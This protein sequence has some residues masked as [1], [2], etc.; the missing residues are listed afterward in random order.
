MTATAAVTTTATAFMPIE[1][2]QLQAVIW[3]CGSYEYSL[4][5]SPTVRRGSSGNLQALEAHHFIL[6]GA[7]LA[8]GPEAEDQLTGQVPGL[9]PSTL[10]RCLD[11]R[12]DV[13]TREQV[14]KGDG[15]Q[16]DNKD[17]RCDPQGARLIVSSRPELP[18]Q[19]LGYRA[20]GVQ[21]LAAI[22]QHARS[23]VF[24]WATV[25]LSGRAMTPAKSIS[26]LL[27]LRDMSCTANA[28]GGE[29]EEEEEPEDEEE[30]KE[31]ESAKE[32]PTKRA[33]RSGQ[34]ERRLPSREG[35]ILPAKRRLLSSWAS[36][37]ASEALS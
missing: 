13:Q 28:A 16:E 33:E 11:L 34:P 24:N 4:Q 23:L 21:P 26:G 10:P 1:A 6:H 20:V 25:L 5:E 12:L 31:E 7:R 22:Q 14:A 32:A 37:L 18:R 8:E 2:Q 30:K 15:E 36:C 27:T 9:D 19:L 35:A 3:D 29:E 17:G